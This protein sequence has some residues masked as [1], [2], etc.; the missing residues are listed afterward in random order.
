MFEGLP[1]HQPMT[2]QPQDWEKLASR[3]G[4]PFLVGT[5][6]T[7]LDSLPVLFHVNG[8][9]R[10]LDTSDDVANRETARDGLA[11]SLEQTCQTS[12]ERG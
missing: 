4:E 6:H 1:G 11:R 12:P 5:D 2:P 7:V 9:V 3:G 8:K 10:T